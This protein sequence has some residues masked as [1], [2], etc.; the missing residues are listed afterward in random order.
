MVAQAKARRAVP[1]LT[2]VDRKRCQAEKQVGAFTLGG[3]IGERT[4]CPNV[5]LYIVTEKMPGKDGLVGSMSLCPACLEICAKV[6]GSDTFTV[7]TITFVKEQETKEAVKMFQRGYVGKAL[8][9]QAPKRE[10]TTP[11]GL[12]SEETDMHAIDLDS[13]RTRANAARMLRI[14]VKELCER[15]GVK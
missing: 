6:K 4:R 1:K 5:P 2:P 9:G 10:L 15:W 8:D 13:Q 11:N 3:T 14:I 7:A 12:V